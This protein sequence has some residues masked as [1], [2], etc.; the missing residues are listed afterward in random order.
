MADGRM[1]QVRSREV[2]VEPFDETGLTMMELKAGEMSL[3][4]T[5]C[6]HGSAPNAAS[7]RRIGYGISYIPAHVRAT[8]PHRPAAL[9]VRGR[10][11]GNFDLLPSPRAEFDPEAVAVDERFFTRFMENYADA[12]RRHAEQFA[13]RDTAATCI[14]AG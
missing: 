6:V 11:K 8:G 9:L 2:I 1:L 12:E 10:N 14:Q 7:H 5:L 4:H 13:R 3:H